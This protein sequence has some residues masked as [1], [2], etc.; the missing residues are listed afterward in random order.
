MPA[1]TAGPARPA[2]LRRLIVSVEHLEPAVRL[3]TGALRLELEWQQGDLA[4]LRMADGVE[5]L[6]H[7]RPVDRGDAAVAIGFR[8]AELAEA[9]QRWT[10]LGG[11]V[12][13]PPAVQPW[14]ERM[15]VV[16]DVDGHIVCI[17]EASIADA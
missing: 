3:Y 2:G 11:R 16:R 5:L 4:Q 17:S 7:R 12:V 15:A 14:G 9:L 10:E 13:D 1:S 6:L 8:T